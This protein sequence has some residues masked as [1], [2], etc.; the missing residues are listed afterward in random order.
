MPPMPGTVPEGT[1]LLTYIASGPNPN[2]FLRRA[3]EFH[4]AYA[5]QVVVV[6]SLQDV[7]EDLS[8][9]RG[10]KARVRIVTHA[11][12]SGMTFP[13]FTNGADGGIEATALVGFARNDSDGLAV[14]VGDLLRP[15]AGAQAIVNV[16][17]ELRNTSSTVL[18][19]FGLDVS[20]EPPGL[21]RVLFQR[22]IELLALRQS[23]LTN[24]DRALLTEAIEFI[25]GGARRDGLQ[26]RVSA[27]TGVRIGDIRRLVSA[28][29]GLLRGRPRGVSS[30]APELRK[31]EIGIT[32]FDCPCDKS[33]R[34]N[35]GTTG[36]RL[37][38]KPKSGSECS[39][40]DPKEQEIP[41]TTRIGEEAL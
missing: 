14:L 28:I 33:R 32:P 19:P 15:P 4:E 10:V 30:L 9:R 25:L 16:L 23:Q 35:N 3:R 24:A 41:P 18:V 38:R 1:P 29:R 20:G 27:E 40:K 7:V 5:L 17:I 31:R 37:P 2:D 8:K 12:W 39:K 34:Q 26:M 13:L 6:D 21:L 36:R 11:N 22:S